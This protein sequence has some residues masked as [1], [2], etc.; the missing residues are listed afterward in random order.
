M[1]KKIMDGWHTICGY[2]VLVEDGKVIRG[3]KEDYNG[4]LVP[5]YV[6]RAV[7]D[8]WTSASGLSVAAFRARVY[9]G[10]VELF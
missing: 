1:S 3:M 2:R 8:G 9:R 7:S 10:T 6:Y 5:A 4:S